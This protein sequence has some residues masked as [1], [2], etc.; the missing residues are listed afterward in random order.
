MTL[1]SGTRLNRIIAISQSIDE[2]YDD[3]DI[4]NGQINQRNQYNQQRQNNQN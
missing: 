1:D 4:R 2:L 3:I